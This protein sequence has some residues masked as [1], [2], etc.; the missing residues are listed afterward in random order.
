MFREIS[1]YD[2]SLRPFHAIDR[3]WMLITAKK[4]D[5]TVNPM[6]ASW[7]GLGILWSMPVATCYIRPQRYTQELMQAQEYHSLCFLGEEHRDALK[8]CGVVSGRDRDKVA[9][10]GLTVVD[11]LEA[12]YFAQSEL[13][14]V[15]RKL[16]CQQLTP[17]CFI[18]RSVDEK[19]YNGDHHHMYISQI[20][21][22]L[23]KE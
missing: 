22:C 19:N 10:T 23:V 7:G 16:Y 21:H 13:V 3:Q 9:E 15:C 2:L 12:P 5:G 17:D 1:P 6:T 14:L 8:L 18:D 4:P 20:V 11:D